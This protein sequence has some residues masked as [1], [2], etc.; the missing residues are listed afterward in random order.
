MQ[1]RRILSI[2]DDANL[3]IVIQSYLED[4]GALV[5][6]VQNGTELTGYLKENRPEAILLDLILP[7]TDGLSL[8]RVIRDYVAAPIIVLSGKNDTMEKIVCLEMGADDYMTKPFEMRELAARIRAVLRRGQ[9]NSPAAAGGEG[10]APSAAAS[11]R[12]PDDEDGSVVSFGAW[13]LDSNQMQLYTQEGKSADLTTGEFKLLAA[14][15][16][17]PHK[18]L[19]RERLFELTRD[20]EFDSYDRAVDIQI[21]RLRKKLN[22]D[23]KNPAIIKTVRGAGYMFNADIRKA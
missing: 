18:V 21:G 3:Q 8:I 17:A 6:T 20:S 23:P 16:A 9:D 2:D 22:D 1:N 7:D 15:A 10:E 5:D 14:L 19:S 13:K 12:A 4:Q 11:A